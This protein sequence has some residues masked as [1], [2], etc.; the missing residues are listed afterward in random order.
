MAIAPSNRWRIANIYD[1]GQI[2]IRPYNAWNSNWDT[3]LTSLRLR[4]HKSDLYQAQAGRKAVGK[5]SPTPIM[6]YAEITW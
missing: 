2:A 6:R 4:S 5:I 1:G 3:T